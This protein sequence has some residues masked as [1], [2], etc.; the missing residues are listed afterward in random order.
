MRPEDHSQE[1]PFTVLLIE[2]DLSLATVLTKRLST[3]KDPSFQVKHASLLAAGIELVSKGGIDVVLL[4]L[5]LPDSRGLETFSKLYDEVPDIPIVVLTGMDDEGVGAETVRSGAQDYL[6]K[7]HIGHGMLPRVLHYAIERHHMQRGLKS[8]TL[9][10]EF[11]GLHNRRGFFTLAEQQFKLARR[12]KKGLL[13]VFVDLDG[14]KQINDAFGHSEGDVALLETTEILKEA[15]RESDVIARVG[16]DEFVVLAI[17]AHPDHAAIL[18]TRLERKLKFRNDR[19]NRKYN[20]SLSWGFSYY[21]PTDPCPL[22]ALLAQADQAM[23]RHKLKK[24]GTQTIRSVSPVLQDEAN[25]APR[26]AVPKRANAPSQ[27]RKILIIED[28]RAIQKF[29]GYRFRK[30]GFE[31]IVANDGKEGLDEAVSKT[32]HLII[33]DLM[34]PE[35]SGEEVCK[36]IREDEDESFANI[37]II[38]LTAKTGDADRIIGKVIGANAYMTKPFSA[39]ELLE[40]V[41]RLLADV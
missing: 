22:E 13:L 4:D 35:F 8:L 40:E 12:A 2:D 19:T 29:L 17:D 9:T 26:A 32:P 14:L 11:T 31:V 30:L 41:E 7:G 38:M 16:G 21:N 33:L 25:N 27:K 18:L 34:L 39:K 15:F 20:L 28:D 37:P 23:Y 3:V 10:D 1:K 24:K 36:A 5:N 6:V